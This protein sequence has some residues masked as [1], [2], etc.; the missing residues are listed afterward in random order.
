[1]DTQ[2]SAAGT[3]DNAA[4][5]R[6]RAESI[7]SGLSSSTTVPG[8][9]MMNIEQL[10]WINLAT[11]HAMLAN[12]SQFA[13]R[14]R[15]LPIR[16]NVDVRQ[17][18]DICRPRQYEANPGGQLHPS[19]VGQQ[20]GTTCVVDMADRGADGTIHSDRYSARI[21]RVARRQCAPPPQVPQSS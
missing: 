11:N 13:R 2:D 8:E 12:G 17:A 10:I 18:Q 5:V 4:D 15:H 6:M 19:T 3:S 1:M 9:I 21:Q 14:C 7:S 16:H 20:S